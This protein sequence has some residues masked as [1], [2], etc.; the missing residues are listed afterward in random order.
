MRGAFAY[1]SYKMFLDKP[2]TGFGFNQF[3][4]FDRPYL[5]D[6]STNIRLE[7]IRGYVH[8]NSFASILVDLGLVGV[9]LYL[10]LIVAFARAALRLYFN[11]AA[12]NWARASAI[13]AVGVSLCHGIQMAFHEVSFST[14]ENCV[15]AIS[16]GLMTA[17]SQDFATEKSLGSNW[18]R[19]RLRREQA[20]QRMSVAQNVASK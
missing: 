2:L 19:W 7:S 1:V 4:V 10:G 9:I 14:V 15:L 16:L 11:R 17:C 6:R 20:V 8:H 18:M 5:D 13:L 3:Q 12:P